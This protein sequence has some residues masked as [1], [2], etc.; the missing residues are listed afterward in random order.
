[1]VIDMPNGQWI[2]VVDVDYDWTADDIIVID[3]D[4]D[5]FRLSR[6]PHPHYVRETLEFYGFVDADTP[7]PTAARTS[8]FPPPAAVA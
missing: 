4:G 8:L 5:R 1:M 3:S 2:D 6:L 7:Y